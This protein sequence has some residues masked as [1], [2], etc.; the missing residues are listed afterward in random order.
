MTSIQKNCVFDFSELRK[1][2][3][4]VVKSTTAQ[5][6]VDV[7]QAIDIAEPSGS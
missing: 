6:S 3:D 2:M 5:D 7:Y 4:L 1:N